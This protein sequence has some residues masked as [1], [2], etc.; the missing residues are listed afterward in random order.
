MNC[1]PEFSQVDISLSLDPQT[2]ALFPPG[3]YLFAF[4]NSTRQFGWGIETFGKYFTHAAPSSMNQVRDGWPTPIY[5]E[6]VL[7]HPYRV[8]SDEPWNVATFHTVPRKPADPFVNLAYYMAHDPDNELG[9]GQ[10]GSDMS[11]VGATGS[12]WVPIDEKPSG[13]I[14]NVVKFG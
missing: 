5:K 8:T 12:R 1:I 9:H 2:Q 11:L 10:M 3:T 6:S 13:T 14:R 7:S 4:K